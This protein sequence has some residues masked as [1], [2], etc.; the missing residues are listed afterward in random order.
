MTIA[1]STAAPA[2]TPAH[3]DIPAGPL[4]RSILA[5]ANQSGASV[6]AVDLPP[7]VAGRAVRGTLTPER[8]L[9]RMLLGTGLSVERIDERTFRIYR[10]ASPVAAPRPAAPVLD[11]DVASGEEIV[12][13]ASKRETRIG[14]YAGAVSILD[15]RS[16]L[17]ARTAARG[18][19]ALVDSIASLSST[20]L[21]PGRNKLII[22]GI[23]DSSFTGPS[24][25]TVGQ[26]LGDVRLNYNAPDPD[27]SLYDIAHVEVLEG[28]QGTL[29]GS[30]SLGGI[31]RL[32]PNAPQMNEWAGSAA[33]GYLVTTGGAP[34]TEVSAMLNAPLACDRL[35]LRVVGYRSLAGGYIED[36]RRHLN[37]VNRSLT[38]G[39]RL[40]LRATLGDGWTVDLGGLAQNI[41]SAD[42]QYAE[43][44]LPPYT[45]ASAIAQ[46][47]DNDY[48]LGYL[49]VS[50]DR[51]GYK[52]VSATGLIGHDVEEQF[53]ATGFPSSI[54]S[55]FSQHNHIVLITN[56]TRLSHRHG[57]GT[58]WLIGA[59]FINDSERLSRTLGPVGA[60]MRI[61][62]IRNSLTGA[63]VYGEG[64]FGLLPRV[65]ITAGGRFAYTHLAGE[66][67]DLP[68]GAHDESRRDEKNVRPMVAIAWR[69]SS[70]LTAYARYQEGF[71]EG[72][73]SVAATGS[74]ISSQ[75]FQGDSISTYELGLRLG[76]SEAGR[77]TA[78]FA[79][80]YAQWEHIQADLV[81]SS[82]LPY[83]ANIGNGRT[84]GAEMK[85]SWRPARGLSAEAG[86]FFND[87]DLT[88]P[89]AI[90]A[91]FR[92]AELP[93]IAR[94]GGRAALDYSTALKG[95]LLLSADASIRYFGHSR[96]GIGP[97]LDVLQG[98][99]TD[100]Q[101][102][103][104][105]GTDRMGVSLDAANVLNAQGNRFALGDPFGVMLGGQV[106]PR[107]PR[108]IRFGVDAAF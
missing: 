13:A 21:G 63:S 16:S 54:P 58:G 104:R 47:F 68:K 55:A 51:D 56:E 28:P 34:G 105:V 30:G 65:Q 42:G 15:G 101:L 46:P 89:G 96:L 39:G 22:R 78:A 17:L 44:G 37:N 91:G 52:L 23:A 100:T 66:V 11:D 72:G 103:V 87:S 69:P 7:G 14:D 50:R 80:V 94:L 48:R 102:G 31:L 83:T 108:T 20:N 98:D 71:R 45:R 70:R 9:H 86:L 41:A 36:I 32:V 75:R 26:Y 99:Y 43:R 85:A 25:A 27:L 67:L 49:T 79:L 19:E 107:R 24:Q 73:L 93:D 97:G 35:A 84:V 1:V 61:A 60:P 92:H 8:A 6:G 76:D 18:T 106:T 88:R 77:F 4:Q 81:D 57:D 5:F 62:G 74:G 10:G 33:A 12:V 82:G 29:Y 53:D 38:T 64:T 40:S 2:A 3:F 95:G 59:S 90:F